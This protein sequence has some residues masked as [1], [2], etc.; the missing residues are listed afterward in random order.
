MGWTVNR[1][2][3][4]LPRLQPLIKGTESTE[5]HPQLYPAHV[6]PVSEEPKLLGT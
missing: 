3:S 6:I 1:D 2:L 4:R 5:E